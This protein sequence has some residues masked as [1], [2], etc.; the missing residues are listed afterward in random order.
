MSLALGAAFLNHQVEELQKSVT[1]KPHAGYGPKMNYAR[2]VDP[3][4]TRGRGQLDNSAKVVRNEPRPQSMHLEQSRER[5]DKQAPIQV[6]DIIVVDASLLVHG[7]GQLKDWCRN[8][9]KEIVIV[10]LE[11]E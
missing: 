4:P 2:A 7:I 6:A 8:N 11:S 10:P 3:R 5:E 9:R 1:T